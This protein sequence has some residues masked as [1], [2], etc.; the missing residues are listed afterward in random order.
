[1]IRK[2]ALSVS[3]LILASCATPSAPPAAKPP[4]PPAC[5]PRLEADVR[6]TP[7]QPAG[8]S[9]VQPATIEEQTATSLF[10]NWVAEL[11]DVGGQNESRARLAKSACAAPH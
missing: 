10:L 7:A 8:A 2:V 6:A 11:V 5:D 3:C 4:A 1:M 9:V